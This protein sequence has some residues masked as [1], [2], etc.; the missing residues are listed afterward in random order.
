MRKLLLIGVVCVSAC[1]TM[2]EPPIDWDEITPWVE[3]EPVA[4]PVYPQEKNLKSF[5]VSAAT[6]N[7]FY[8]DAPS[9]SIGTDGVVHYTLVVKSPQGAKNITFEGMRCATKEKKVYALGHDDGTWARTRAPKWER[10]HYKDTNRQHH[11]L[12][13]DFLCPGAIEA[14]SAQE[15]IKALEAGRHPRAIGGSFLN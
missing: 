1:A 12:Y 3:Q 9:I 2:N 7:K 8:L 13:D 10:I 4:L 5:F 6:D 15:V 14:G 11:M